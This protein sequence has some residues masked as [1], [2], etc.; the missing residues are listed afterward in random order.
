MGLSIYVTKGMDHERVD[1]RHCKLSIHAMIRQRKRERAGERDSTTIRNHIILAQAQ[2]F[3][4][5]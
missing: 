3:L 1:C 2:G 4:E 5:E